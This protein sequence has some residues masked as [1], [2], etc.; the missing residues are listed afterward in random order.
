MVALA[1]SGKFAGGEIMEA[2]QGV[3]AFSDLTGE[4]IEKSVKVFEKLESSPLKTLKELDEQY[5]FLTA[6]QY[7]QVASLE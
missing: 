4:S 7:A 6:S 3:V 5:H 1:A 2:A